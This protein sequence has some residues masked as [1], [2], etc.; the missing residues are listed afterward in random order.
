[1]QKLAFE[2]A[3][4]INRVTPITPTSLVTLS[5]LGGGDRAAHRAGDWSRACCNLV[6]YVRRRAAADHRRARPRHAARA[7][8]AALD[9][10]G[11]ERRRQPLTPRGST[12]S[13]RSAPSSTSP[14]PT[15]ATP[16][17]ISSSTARSPSWR[18]CAP[19]RAS[20]TAAAAEFWDEALRLRDLLKFE[21]FF[22]EK[23]AFRSRAARR[24]RPARPRLGAA[25]GAG[26]RGGARLVR[27]F[28]PFS[29]HRVLRPFLEAYRV[30]ADALARHDAATP[31]DEA[32]VP[33]QLPGARQAVPAAAPHPQ[34]GVGV[35]GALRDRAAPGAQ[36][37]PARPP[38]VPISPS[39]A[40]PS[41]GRSA[42]PS[43]ASTPSTRSPPAAWRA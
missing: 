29:A 10:L 4:R 35:E 41:A 17:S 39:A 22:A 42:T 26:R 7:C 20:P 14:P 9:Q 36:P 12:R 5:L 33:L 32:G 24:A 2:V 19:P 40:A 21:F 28:R 23:E 1:M 30:V 11:R 8:S 43:A 31:V 25:L 27:R 13:T 6:H 18:C 34:R 37:Q 3:V 16:S 15:T 38:T